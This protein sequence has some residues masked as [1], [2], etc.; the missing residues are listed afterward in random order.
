M[1]KLGIEA[2]F[3]FVLFV[4]L[5]FVIVGLLDRHFSREHAFDGINDLGEHL[6]LS[7]GYDSIALAN[8]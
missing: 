4:T 6:H 2:G 8:C 3:L 5:I 7:G 1:A